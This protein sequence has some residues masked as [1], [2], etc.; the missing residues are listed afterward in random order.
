MAE[1]NDQNGNG[2]PTSLEDLREEAL[3][4]AGIGM[5]RYTF[6]GTV[7]LGSRL[8]GNL[9]PAALRGEYFRY[10]VGSLSRTLPEAG[11]IGGAGY[12]SFHNIR[13]PIAVHIRGEKINTGRT[14]V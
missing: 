14:H 3:R 7:L 5:Y 8:V 2:R 6:D 12:K 11:I 13:F 9:D 4:F 1:S 10:Q